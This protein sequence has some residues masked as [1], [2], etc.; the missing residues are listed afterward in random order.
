[1]HSIR[2][3]LFILCSA[4][5]LLT[6]T[7]QATEIN[8]GELGA[9]GE[10][11]DVTVLIQQAIDEVYEKGGGLVRLP[12][13]K[14]TTGTLFLKSNVI[15]HL[16]EGAELLGTSVYERYEEVA[17]VYETFFLREDRYPKRVMI[18]AIDA[19]NAAIQGAGVIDGNG[20]HP[21]LNLKRMEAV[22]TIRFI[23]CTNMKIEGVGGRL[24]IKNS[25]HWTV[26]PVNVDTL[27]IRNVFISNFGGNTPDG[28][29]ISDCRN[30]L[31]ENVEVEADD[32]AITLKSG[33][34]EI[35][36]EN[37]T[38]R[39]CI[40]RSRVCGFKTG[41]QS[42]GTIR[43]V[44]ISDCHFEGASEPPGTQYDPQNGIFLN[45][46]NGGKLEDI[47]VKDCT[48]DGFPS[49]LSVVLSQLN[50]DYW[51]S[52]WPDRE[53]PGDFGS[54]RNIS[55]ENITG[56]NLG[57]LGIL[58]EG[59]STSPIENISFSG[60]NLSTSGLGTKVEDFPEKPHA[61]PNMFYLHKQIPAYGMYIRHVDKI[62]LK[63]VN[64]TCQE[65][66]ERPAFMKIDVTE[67]D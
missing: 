32:D 51:K 23:R 16:D 65:K 10:G 5:F 48:T 14:Y 4:S 7:Q 2:V 63:E 1:M 42:F 54:I 61:Y 56:N 34:P 45:V 26:Q 17:P 19:T 25:S 35:V 11:D 36:M 31:V 62:S 52:Y 15:L 39:N 27:L 20:Q 30:V 53:M 58:I 47:V 8:I 49:S 29:A 37:I 6:C 21:N 13:G 22:N 12:A 9:T 67:I 28:L 60:L 3:Y 41:P 55:F 33:T 38:I 44:L 46:S 64:I 43:N 18:V 66:D 24:T 40:G 57:N 50:S 59:R